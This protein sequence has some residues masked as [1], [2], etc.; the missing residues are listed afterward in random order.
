MGVKLVITPH[1]AKDVGA[2]QKLNVNASSVG[3]LLQIM[4]KKAS[5]FKDRICDE[6]GRIR[7]Y[8]NVFVNGVNI[9]SKEGVLS[10]P[11]S[12][13]DSVYILPSVAGGL[14]N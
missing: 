10:T 3:D 11:L 9:R 2:G 12:D 14:F 8:V 1:L 4:D 13:G 6:N 7:P 5:G